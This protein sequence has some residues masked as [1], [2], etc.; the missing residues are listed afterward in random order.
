[1][2]AP[3]IFANCMFQTAKGTPENPSLPETDP[4]AWSFSKECKRSPFLCVRIREMRATPWFE[5]SEIANVIG[6]GSIVMKE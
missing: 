6:L 4:R 2:K 5:I 3:E 1:L